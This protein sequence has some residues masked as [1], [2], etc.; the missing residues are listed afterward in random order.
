[1]KRREFLKTS[2]LSSA[3]IAVSPFILN[4]CTKRIP[5]MVDFQKLFPVTKEDMDKIIFEALARGGDYADLFFEYTEESRLTLEE[6]IIKEAVTGISVGMGVR[7]IIGDQIGYAYSE[8]LDL[9]K[10]KEAAKTASF[11]ANSKKD[12]KPVEI[13]PVNYKKLYRGYGFSVEDPLKDK[14]KLLERAN[15]AALEYDSK[16]SKVKV[17]FTDELKNIMFYDSEGK[18]FQDSQPMVFLR[19]YSLAE[20]GD[21]RFESRSGRSGRYGLDIFNNKEF[22]PE[23]IG[24]ESSETAVKNLDARPGPAGPQVVVL[25]KCD[26]GILL[27]EAV[28]HGL[29]ADFNRKNLS[30]FSGKIG[31]KVA[32]DQCTIIDAGNFDNL[33]G[34]INVDDE[35][36]PSMSTVLIENGIL[37]GYMQDHI[38][39]K[40][41]KTNPSGNGRRQSFKHNPMPRMTNTYMNAGKYDYE[42]I[43]GS[44]KKGVFAK[45]FSGGQ[46]D[47][48]KGDFTFSV[49]EGYMIENGKLTY[50][51]K[52]L[53]LIGNGPDVMQK[54]SMVGND[55]V[56]TN[57]R[58]TCGK[59]GQSVPVGIGIPTVKVSEITVGGTV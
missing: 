5:K 54:V 57:R 33:R 41:L 44:V 58:W 21:K 1:M 12:Y 51:L 59:N 26:S 35:G 40:E 7:V 20:K 42:E 45:D 18:F 36:N 43:I 25:G 2:A 28:G 39:A 50:P 32:S 29:E 31:Q 49:T 17:Y 37:K 13:K 19:A 6:N 56:F 24:T 23:L 38:S 30:K 27:H 22:K 55:L 14:I 34:S 15:K 52:D 47:I 9:A 3:T 11:I 8:D 16:I 46:V 48:T 4:N 53:T 10:L